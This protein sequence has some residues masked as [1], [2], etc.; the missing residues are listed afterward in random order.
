[1]AWILAAVVSA[2]HGGVLA[3]DSEAG[4]QCS[5]TAVP[6]IDSRLALS[7]AAEA[8]AVNWTARA[9]WMDTVVFGELGQKHGLLEVVQAAT[10][11]FNGSTIDVSTYVGAGLKRETFPVL[12]ALLTSHLI[13]NGAAR[14]QSCTNGVPNCVDG[15]I[16]QYFDAAGLVDHWVASLGR[17]KNASGVIVPPVVS[18]GQL[19]DY[20]FSNIMV[21]TVAQAYGGASQ[22]AWRQPLLDSARQWHAAMVA[23]GGTAHST[24]E[25]NI[26]GF[27]FVQMKPITAPDI[28]RQPSSSAALAYIMTAAHELDP[29]APE[30]IE[31]ADWALT[32]LCDVLPS[33][34]RSTG[35]SYY[36]ENMLVR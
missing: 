33:R 13:G 31:G 35:G 3:T 18:G 14:Q 8:V 9:Q 10:S 25:F 4:G 11:L 15:T 7:A 26:S 32:Y 17:Q 20:L 36:F 30:F 2:G 16:L 5:S 24:P 28:F 34:S 19:W 6:E 21:H 22:P 23:M 12:G 29:T 27:D 1:M